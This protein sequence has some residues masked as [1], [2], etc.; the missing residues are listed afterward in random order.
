M[1]KSLYTCYRFPPAIIQRASWLYFR[2]NLSYRD[3]EDMLAERG[4]DVF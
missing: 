4:V 3:I 2:F 1:E